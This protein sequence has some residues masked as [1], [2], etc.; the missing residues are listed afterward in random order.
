MCRRCSSVRS[1]YEIKEFVE[2]MDREE[3]KSNSISIGFV[4]EEVKETFELEVLSIES[5]SK[6]NSLNMKDCKRLA[7]RFGLP[8]EKLVGSGANRKFMVLIGTSLEN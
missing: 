6:V 1:V 4:G 7:D 8:S 3:L 2:K 5:P